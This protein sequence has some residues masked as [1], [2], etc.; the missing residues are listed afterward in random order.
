MPRFKEDDFT[1]EIQSQTAVFRIDSS[2][3]VGGGYQ[4]S[5]RAQKEKVVE[6]CHH[7]RRRLPPHPFKM[8]IVGGVYGVNVVLYG[9]TRSPG[10]KKG[11]GSAACREYQIAARAQEKE[12]VEECHH[13]RR[14]LVWV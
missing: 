3:L 2:F 12:I 6:K 8:S 1:G 13:V 5:A 10:F 7:V 9:E 11:A 14:R 4:V